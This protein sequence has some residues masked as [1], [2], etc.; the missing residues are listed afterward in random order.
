MI[1]PPPK[2]EWPIQGE[3]DKRIFNTY[4]LYHRFQT[5]TSLKSCFDSLVNVHYLNATITLTNTLCFLDVRWHGCLCSSFHLTK[6]I[7]L[8]WTNVFLLRPCSKLPNWVWNVSLCWKRTICI[9]QS[10][11][12]LLLLVES[13]WINSALF[14]VESKILRAEVVM[15][16]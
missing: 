6:S 11:L 16:S 4:L 8:Q 2:S 10:L 13:R 1:I 3:S 14:V 5:F 15:N 12:I 9:N 7:N